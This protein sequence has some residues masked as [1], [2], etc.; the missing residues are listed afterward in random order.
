MVNPMTLRNREDW[1][2]LNF[3]GQPE[4]NDRFANDNF[5]YV[6]EFDPINSIPVIQIAGPSSGAFFQVGTTPVTFRATDAAGNFSQCTFSVEV[7]DTAAPRAICQDITL[8]LDANGQAVLLPAGIDNGSYG[9]CSAFSL[10]TSKTNFDYSDLGP[11]TVRLTATDGNGRSSFCDAT[12]TIPDTVTLNINCPANM[13]VSNDPGQCG[14]QV[15]FNITAS[16]A[17][18]L[19]T[20]SHN[21]GDYFHWVPPPYLPQLLMWQVNR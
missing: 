17:G 2:T 9:Y 13:M 8:H 3:D 1:G 20:S 7:L 19:I 6:V 14:A 10:S 16:G 5:H 21:S 4:W 15:N 18:T 12:V 11:N